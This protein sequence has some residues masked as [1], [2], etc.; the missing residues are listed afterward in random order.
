MKKQ[1]DGAMCL[2]GTPSVEG[3][4]AGVYWWRAPAPDEAKAGK[5]ADLVSA[6]AFGLFKRIGRHPLSLSPTTFVTQ[7]S[8]HA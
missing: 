2:R 7:E 8:C 1:N 4:Q 3:M 6:A 5:L